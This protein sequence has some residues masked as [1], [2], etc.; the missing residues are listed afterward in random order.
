MVACYCEVA[1]LSAVVCVGEVNGWLEVVSYGDCVVACVGNVD[2]VC[3][4][5]FNCDELFS[6]SG[7]AFSAFVVYR[8]RAFYF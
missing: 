7:F 8:V 3:I 4:I 5:L 1:I 6:C 2:A